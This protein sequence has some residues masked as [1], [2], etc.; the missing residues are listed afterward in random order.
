MSVRKRKWRTR[1]GEEKEVWVV[2][3]SAQDGTR[4]LKTFVRKKD[5]DAY[6]SQVNVDVASGIHTPHSRSITVAEAAADWLKHVAAEGRERTTVNQ[7]R[8]HV[9]LHILPRIG[10]VK[11][12]QLSTPFV[13][14]FRDELLTS[15]LSRIL[16]RKVIGSMKMLL[17]DAQRRGSVAQNVALGVSVQLSRRDKRKLRVGEDIPSPDEVRRIIEAAAGRHRALLV[18]ACFTGLRSSELRGLRW[19][20]V[21]LEGEAPQLHVRQRADRYRAIGNLK[22]A[23]GERSIPLGPFLSNTLKSLRA[24]ERKGE[25]VFGNASGNSEFHQS[26]VQRMLHPAQVKAGVVDERGKPKYPGLH[27]LRHFFAS[28]CINR[29][30]DGGLELPLKRVQELLGHSTLAMTADVY[31]HLFP[32]TDAHNELAAAEKA[33]GLHVA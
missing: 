10:R 22:S 13:N 25:Y 6:H 19:S 14:K 1:A 2:D 5:A 29:R 15:G 33:M 18:T 24:M 32:S 28:W 26:M 27:C 30:V 31:G 23:S 16:A 12:A 11:L 17:K 20:D 4:H 3:Y 8:Q 21:E 9:E 7:Y